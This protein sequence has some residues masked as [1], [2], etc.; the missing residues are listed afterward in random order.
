M[1]GLPR[2][3]APLP[4]GFPP[5][6]LPSGALRAP[7]AAALSPP[8]PRLV[9]VKT[10]AAAARHTRRYFSTAPLRAAEPP[11][12]TQ[13]QTEATEKETIYEDYFP[14]IPTKLVYPRLT[15][16][17]TPATEVTDSGYKP[18]ETA[19]GLEEVG[20]L[21]G[22][23]DE[24]THWGSE[25]GVAA[26]VRTAAPQF[27]PAEKITDPAVLEVL[28][29][30]AIVEALVVARFAGGGKVKL[31]DQLFKHC[32]ELYSLNK[33]IKIEVAAGKDGAATLTQ[34]GD[35]Q[36]VWDILKAADRAASQQQQQQLSEEAGAGEEAGAT[37]VATK[38]DRTINPELAQS[39]I[40]RWDRGWKKAELR[41]PVVKFYAAKRIQQ[42]TGHRIP[43]GKLAAIATIDSFVKNIVE[44]P[45]PKK[46]FE[47]VETKEMFKDQSNVKIY[48]RRV[49]PID[50]EQMVGRWKVIVKELK[51][52]D[53]PLTGTGDHG[54]PIEKK[55]I[56]GDAYASWR[57]PL[58]ESGLLGHVLRAVPV[59][60]QPRHPFNK[61]A[62]RLLGNSCADCDENRARVVEFG[63][64]P[65][66]VLNLI[67]NPE[68]D[69][70]LPFTIAATLNVCVDCPDQR[71]EPAQLQASEA[72]LS[73]ALLNVVSGD[74]LSSCESSLSH[75]MTILELLTSQDSEPKAAN[76]NTPALLFSLA[77]SD[78]YDADLDSFMEICTPA[79][80]Y[81]TFQ[82][83]QPVLLESG[84][85]QVLQQ[86]FHQLYTRFDV[87]DLDPDTTKQ[88]KQ[89]L[90]DWLGLS[91]PLSHLQT[92]ACLS[93]GNLSR[94]D[95]S[96]TTLINR[97]QEPLID[98]LSRSI[99]PSASQPPI[100]QRPA[101]PLQLTH[102]TLSFLKN[103][104]IAQPNK[105]LLG[106]SLLGGAHPLLPQLWTSTR[107]QPQ[108]QFAAVSLTRL[109]LAACPANVRHI[110]APLAA[111]AGSSSS[112]PSNLA[113][114]LSTA[115]SADEDPIKMEAARAASL[116][117]R[118]LYS[119]SNTSEDILDPAWT[120][121]ATP[122]TEDS[123][124]PTNPQEHEQ[125]L[126][127]FYA[128]HAHPLTRALSHL[129][130]QPRFLPVRSDTI[131]VLALMARTSAAGAHLAL[132][133]LHTGN[134]T[135]GAGW[136]ALAQA[137]AGSESK[138]AKAFA[139]P[140]PAQAVPGRAGQRAAASRGSPQQGRRAGRPG[141][142]SGTGVKEAEDIFSLCR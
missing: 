131:F 7:A 44:P 3:R 70:L 94:S 1:R 20:G 63:T 142:R 8:T 141:A 81:L 83:L 22:W 119:S 121:T 42:L 110:C 134:E 26:V 96:S 73:K 101:A 97:V 106:A 43:D 72:G 104:A 107:T 34:K 48:P 86:A 62:L 127:A 21:S 32:H 59:A 66:F 112:S 130:T 115:A 53:L 82:D 108:L 64:L 55:W 30:R 11:S 45:K 137:I 68:A 136:Q 47:L 24:P 67:K 74:R 93:L 126:T 18:A 41:D 84:G 60:N 61:Q 124:P 5:S 76:P 135:L 116:V 77:T 111:P 15:T 69:P 128:T 27:G 71:T 75:I 33:I 87:A 85:T 123:T 54:P 6:S 25:E 100:P 29:K 140:P 58:G 50:K 12:Q 90:V 113:L 49:T 120:W 78:G 125:S 129:L 118:A 38:L 31:V 88:L 65:N 4:A 117:C 102:A 10:T 52:R 13:S 14:D 114:L 95:E 92:A 79:L 51:K 2:I 23:W 39:M 89:I 98:I 40:E 56:S 139:H 9:T 109:L 57:A 99:P 91:P 133:I 132:Q 105:P 80:A 16:T 46:L 103:L 19:E 35:W 37:E 122:S 36:S 28:A 138:L 17:A